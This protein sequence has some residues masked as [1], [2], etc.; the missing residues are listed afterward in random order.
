MRNFFGG[1]PPEYCYN[2]AVS[3][4][5]EQAVFIDAPFCARFGGD[6]VYLQKSHTRNPAAFTTYE[7]LCCRH[8]QQSQPLHPTAVFCAGGRD[9]DTCCIDAAVT[10]NMPAL[11]CLFPYYK[12]SGPKAFSNYEGTPCPELLLPAHIAASWPPKYYFCSSAFQFVCG[13]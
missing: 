9:V 3:T 4:A 2:C 13:R 8:G 12:M 1:I 11:Q 6:S 7:K 10:E 5:N